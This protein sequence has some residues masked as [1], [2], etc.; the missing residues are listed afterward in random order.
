MLQMTISC[1]LCWNIDSR[2]IIWPQ[3]AHFGSENESLKGL[4][5]LLPNPMGDRNDEVPLYAQMSQIRTIESPNLC[6]SC[7]MCA[8]NRTCH[9]LEASDSPSVFPV[10]GSGGG[11]VV[12]LLDSIPHWARFAF[13]A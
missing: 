12:Q 7:M 4:R 9:V 8:T 11:L 13:D 2:K 5:S 1:G 3:R 10:L 6:H